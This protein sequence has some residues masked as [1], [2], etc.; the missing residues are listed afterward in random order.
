MKLLKVVRAIIRFA[1]IALIALT[2]L[3]VLVYGISMFD[4]SMLERNCERR[5]TSFATLGITV[6]NIKLYEIIKTVTGLTGM[7]MCVIELRNTRSILDSAIAGKP[8][9]PST[10]RSLRLIGCCLLMEN[11]LGELA[12]FANVYLCGYKTPLTTIS[13][14]GFI[15]AIPISASFVTALLI[16]CLAQ[17]FAYGVQL[18]QDSDGLL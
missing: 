16:L 6:E 7:L 14:N 17:A 11:L 12:N 15:R 1:E 8:F 18:Q 10:V 2:I 5:L 9:V 3:C 4:A 13:I